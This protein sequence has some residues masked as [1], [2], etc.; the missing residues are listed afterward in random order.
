M[1][2]RPVPAPTRSVPPELG[3][4][5][6]APHPGPDVQA[7]G[8]RR[9]ERPARG[10][11]RRRDGGPGCPVARCAVARHREDGR[12]QPRAGRGGTGDRRAPPDAPP[13]ADAPPRPAPPPPPPP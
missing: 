5:S 7:S 2:T 8:R 12:G 10:R 9:R 4:R 1:G 6:P 3:G 11:G 13:P